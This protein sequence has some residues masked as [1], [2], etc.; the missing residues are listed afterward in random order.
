[1]ASRLRTTYWLRI[2]VDMGVLLLAG[3]VTAGGSNFPTGM[4]ANTITNSILSTTTSN[5]TGPAVFENF[6]LGRVPR[7]LPCAGESSRLRRETARQVLPGQE[8]L[9][10]SRTWASNTPVNTS[11]WLLNWTQRRYSPG[12]GNS[13]GSDTREGAASPW[14]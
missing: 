5:T 13:Y 14:P 7:A 2:R 6:C 11:P 12:A 10:W 1:M 8:P 3:L 4:L 9:G